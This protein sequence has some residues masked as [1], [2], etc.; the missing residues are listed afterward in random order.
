[1]AFYGQTE[2]EY[3]NALSQIKEELSSGFPLEN[4]SEPI[5]FLKEWIAEITLSESLYKKKFDC[6][7]KK[8]V[9]DHTLE[10]DILGNDDLDD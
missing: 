8:K 2:L 3:M 7:E 4:P 5:Y 9:T 6:Q 1:M 10:R